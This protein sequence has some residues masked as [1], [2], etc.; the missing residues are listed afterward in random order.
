MLEIPIEL[1]AIRVQGDCRTGEQ[2]FVA[3][4]RAA[5]D[6]QPWLCLR[7][8]P[9]GLIEI[10]IVA[11]GDPRI[12]PGAQKIRKLSPCI[13]AWLPGARDVLKFPFGS[14]GLRVPRADIA[15]RFFPVL[16]TTRESTEHF[17]A[18]HN[19]TGCRAVALLPTGQFGLPYDFAGTRVQCV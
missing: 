2:S 15:A 13:P 12:A 17:A 1:S 11:A 6:T 8:A 7:Y 5:T 19:R 18:N 3:G 9:I 14:S 4:L 10:G 16:S